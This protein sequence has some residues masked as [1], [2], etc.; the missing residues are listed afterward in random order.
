MQ[1]KQNNADYA[2]QTGTR[3]E[4]DL[5]KEKHLKKKQVTAFEINGLKGTIKHW[6]T[7]IY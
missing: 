1:L 6:C 5:R 3:A 7:T 4:K 2:K